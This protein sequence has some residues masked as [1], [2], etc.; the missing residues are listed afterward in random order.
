MLYNGKEQGYNSNA[1]GEARY[2][3]Q[4]LDK[5]AEDM[6]EKYPD[7]SKGSMSEVV[8]YIDHTSPCILPMP[9]GRL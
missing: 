9:N 7:R 1:I 6:A 3:G 4:S 8:K 2:L 5:Y